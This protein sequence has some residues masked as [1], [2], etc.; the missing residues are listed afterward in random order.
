MDRLERRIG[1]ISFPGFLRY[2][3]L[4][5]VLVFVLQ[6]VRPDIGQL[7]EFDRAKILSGEV[8]RV[9]TFFFAS[10]QFGRPNLMSILFLIFAVN[11]AFMI[12]DGLEEAW[13]VFK[14]TVFYFMGI[15]LT[16]VAN[17]AYPFNIPVS[18]FVLYASAFLAF[19]TL[20]P[21]REIL[22]FLI[23]PV[24]IRF[25][26]IFQAVI[27][28]MMILRAPILLPYAVL[29]FANYIL[30]AGIPALRGTLRLIESG[31]RKKRFTAS[32]TPADEA[33]H[34]CAACDRTDASDP[35]LEFRVGAD[36]REYCA[37]H[38]RD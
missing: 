21:K 13:G 30:L 20:F 8:W 6:F 29:G 38:L 11:F 34:T 15:G 7:L 35:G 37:D 4:F 3:A 5:H 16:V 12:G 25:L 14:T 36:G 10:S 24:Q 31:Q 22:L 23:L 32:K 17:F 28:G 27:L 9:V 2:Y 33:F 26:G 18:G 1:W 19:A